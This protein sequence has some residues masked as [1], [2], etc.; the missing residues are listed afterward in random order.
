[1]SVACHLL[2]PGTRQAIPLE[3]VARHIETGQ[4]LVWVELRG[5]DLAMVRRLEK[6]LH[7]HE[8]AVEDALSARQR[9]KVEDYPGG[10]FLVL[11][12]ARWWNEGVDHG[13]THI[14]CGPGYLACIRHDPGP[15]Y[16]N[17][18]ERLV[19]MGRDIN[20]GLALYALLDYVVDDL[21]PLVDRLLESHTSLEAQVFEEGFSQ[22][23][24]RNLY[25]NK[26]EIL[27]LLSTVQP[28]PEI[29]ENLIRLHPGIVEEDLRAYYRDVEDHALRLIQ[30]LD[31]LRTMVGDT[32][33]LALATASMEQSEAVQKLAGWGA[34]IA[35]PTLIFSLYGMNFEV[36]PELHWPWAY[37]L[38]LAVTASICYWLYRY[39][40][41]RGW[42]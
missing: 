16:I 36:M 38:V 1:M 34:I 37:P 7:L 9:P 6:E 41:R 4:G 8:L 17:V 11:R 22:D 14:F 30:A 29:C 20:P 21:R 32:M 15:A 5:I 18:Q 27:K 35:V 2:R 24:L 39:L 19:H 23:I 31:R 12:T 40:R 26:R 42:I 10:L 13:E 25:D 3:A 28:L 33:Q